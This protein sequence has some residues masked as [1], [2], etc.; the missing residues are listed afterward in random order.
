DVEDDP[1][2]VGGGVGVVHVSPAPL[3]VVDELIEIV[4]QPL[5]R[6]LLDGPRAVAQSLALREFVE[7]LAPEVDE[8]RG[9]DGQRLAQELIVEGRRRALAERSRQLGHPTS[10]SRTSARCR[11]R[12][13]ELRRRSRPPICMR[14]PASQATRHEAPA[15]S[16]F[17]SL[18]STIDDDT[19]GSRTANEPPK[20]QHSSLAGS[21]TNSAPSRLRSSVRGDSDS[22]SPRLRWQESWY[23]RRPGIA[24]RKRVL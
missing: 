2:R 12:I 5:E 23:V 7:R 19:S 3:D 9:R 11:A 15:A 1:A 17:A 22:P 6:G 20:P 21:S 24:L 18:R 13:G 16:T 4:I 10:A 14:Q 8:L